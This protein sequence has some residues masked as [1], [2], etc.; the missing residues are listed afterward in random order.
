M[1]KESKQ[2]LKDGSVVDITTTIATVKSY[3]VDRGL[4]SEK[5][6]FNFLGRVRKN[7]ATKIGEIKI[8]AA[9]N[10]RFIK[11]PKLLAKSMYTDS[12][13]MKLK[14]I[15]KDANN[16]ITSYT[17]NLVYGNNIKITRGNS[18]KYNLI[19]ETRSIINKTTGIDNVDFG[20]VI[21]DERGGIKNIT[22]LG[23]PG[24]YFKLAI[25]KF[26]DGDVLTFDDVEYGNSDI[27]ETSIL[28]SKN[29][30]TTHTSDTGS[31]FNVVEGKIKSNRKYLI[32]QK[33]DQ[34][35]SKT[36][37]SVNIYPGRNGSSISSKF[38]LNNWTKDRFG[39][40]GWYSR[41]ITQP[42][43]PILTLQATCSDGGT[44]TIGPDAA[45]Q[46]TINAST[47]YNPDIY[48]IKGRYN[49][50]IGTLPSSYKKT[51]ELVYV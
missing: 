38:N 8:T 30:N 47:P 43:H 39:W 10:K 13:K 9:E 5:T 25:N 18:L 48:K 14:N 21:V 16:N 46:T 17:Y 37:Y 33:F 26:D 11:A 34:I 4:D 42:T 22:V 51:L 35:S 12:L 40:S 15:E 3:A 2:T 7:R 6:T 31:I 32:S 45:T 50:P 28:N 41:I 44:N 29:Y 20:S 19:L 24:T 49:K 1:L 23:E 27:N 36:R